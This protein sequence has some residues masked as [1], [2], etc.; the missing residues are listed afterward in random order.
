MKN[1]G[2]NSG[3]AINR[4]DLPPNRDHN[5]NSLAFR[6]I[7]T[8][9]LLLYAITVVT[10]SLVQRYVSALYL[11][12]SRSNE[13][14]AAVSASNLVSARSTKLNSARL[15]I[16]SVHVSFPFLPPA[17]SPPHFQRGIVRPR[18]LRGGVTPDNISVY[19]DKKQTR[20]ITRGITEPNNMSLVSG[21]TG[22]IS[23]E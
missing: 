20:E 7:C 23:T 13:A 1:S 18:Q 19:N 14:Q 9:V 2:R 16:Q 11:S 12:A 10:L 6:R 4:R 21:E 3:G 5:F 17:P 22:Y 15:A 8:V